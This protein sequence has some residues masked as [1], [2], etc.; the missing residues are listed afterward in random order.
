M[1]LYSNLAI[2]RRWK[3]MHIPNSLGKNGFRIWGIL[4]WENKSNVCFTIQFRYKNML[5]DRSWRQNFRRHR[6]ILR[7]WTMQ[8]FTVLQ[9]SFEK[10]I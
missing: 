10:C 4:N 7:I 5:S 9:V 1:L 3:P 6:I 8:G 2:V